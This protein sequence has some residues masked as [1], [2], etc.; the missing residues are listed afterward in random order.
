MSKTNFK[1]L[2][3]TAL[4]CAAGG[5][6]QAHLG[7]FELQD[8]Y[9]P[10]LNMVQNYNAGQYGTNSGYM[11]MAPVAITPSTGLWHNINGGFSSGGAT[12]YATGHQWY[13]RTWVNSGG[14]SGKL[15]DQAL[16][17]T[18]GHQGLT[19][20]ALK[21]KYD[22]DSQD[23]GGVNPLATGGAVVTMSFWVRGFLDG[24]LVGNGY[25]GNEI[26]FEDSLG[27]VGFSLGHTKTSGGDMVT[28]WNGA[29]MAVSSITGSMSFYDRWD[30]VFD[31][32]N[33]TVSA[34]YYQ[35]IT[36]T[37]TTLASGVAMQ[38]ALADF[39]HMT[40]RTSPGVTNGKYFSVDDF[41]FTT[42]V[43]TPGAAALAGFAG[44]G[45][46]RRRR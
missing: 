45:L 26:T 15:A 29:S 46:A 5:I 21:Y 38:N 42:N 13:D 18:T 27:N 9:Q 39:S 40:F 14:T 44:L 37:S 2:S 20:P 12:S 6:A 10:F 16:V 25:F 30:L 8:G 17:L 19:G 22:I 36:N 7:S 23:L 3:A 41:T 43:P 28:C 1:F 32:G 34:S 4:L 35:F 24:G 11:A 31:L 33:N